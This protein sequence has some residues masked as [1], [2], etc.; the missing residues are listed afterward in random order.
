MS[1]DEEQTTSGRRVFLRTALAA[2]L[3]VAAVFVAHKGVTAF[4]A[5]VE[6]TQQQDGTQGYHLTEHITAY[7]QSASL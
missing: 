1:T 7:Y 6:E 4:A 2:S 3:S 5:P